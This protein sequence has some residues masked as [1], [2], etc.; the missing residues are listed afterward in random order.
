MSATLQEIRSELLAVR[1]AGGYGSASKGKALFDQLCAEAARQ[2]RPLTMLN[3][4]SPNEV[5]RF[6]SRT[7]PGPDGHVYWTGGKVFRRNDGAN[8]LPIRWWWQH[9]HGPITAFEDVTLTCGDA[10][11]INPEHAQVGRSER[12]MMFTDTQMIGSLQVAAMRAGHTP[13]EL[14]WAALGL[15]PSATN[16]RL[17]FG[18]WTNACRA[19]GLKPKGGRTESEASAIA[20]LRHVLTFLGH[21]PSATEFVSHVVRDELRRVGLPSAHT[22]IRS[23]LGGIW[24][25]ALRKA[26]KP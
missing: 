11:C 9:K 5:E 15:R 6:F 22:T 18:S 10:K 23:Y 25:D 1:A 26:G 4:Y 2:G 7:L 17:R 19:A 16:Y 12:R 14:E 21:W 24:A 20:S 3:L 8:R 13:S